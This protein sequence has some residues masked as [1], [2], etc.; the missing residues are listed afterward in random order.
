MNNTE[1]KKKWEKENMF[2]LGLKLHRF[3]DADIMEFLEEKGNDKQKAIKIALRYYLSHRK[4]VD[5]YEAKRI[6]KIEEEL[7]DENN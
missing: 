3:K 6:A 5:N 4:V 2:L 7:M 1:A